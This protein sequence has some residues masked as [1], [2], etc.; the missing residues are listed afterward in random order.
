MKY[1][2][3]PLTDN[4]WILLGDGSR[5]GLVNSIDNKI[6]VIGNITPKTYD[7]IGDLQKRLGGKIHI[8]KNTP[9]VK[10][11]ELGEVFGF[12]VKHKSVHDLEQEP[13]P[14]Y[15][16]SAKSKD[17]YAAGYYAIKFTNG[18]TPWF[19]PRLTTIAE[20]EFLGPFKTK[21]EMNH[22]ISAKNKEKTI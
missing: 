13:V 3:R 10:E 7:S 9:S 21:I 8:E 4:S 6:S 5:I 2:L 18:W 1:V 14:N 19:C 16:R 12:P 22:Q 20:H 11:V 15:L 17:R